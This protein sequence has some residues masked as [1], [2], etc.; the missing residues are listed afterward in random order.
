LG[1]TQD[2]KEFTGFVDEF[3]A[4]QI[5]FYTQSYQGKIAKYKER[6]LRQLD[7]DKPF[8]TYLAKI[9]WCKENQT[10][11]NKLVKK[12][13]HGDDLFTLA[14]VVVNE[15]GTSNNKAKEAI[16]YAYLNRTGGQVREPK[17][18]EISHYKILNARFAGIDTTGRYTFVPNFIK[19][20]EAANKRLSDPDK[21]DDPTKGATHW[22]S[23]SGL[24]KKRSDC[25]GDYYWRG[26]EYN[27]CFP[28]WARDKDDPEVQ[29][30]FKMGLHFNP[31]YK[32]LSVPHVDSD[33]FLFYIG[34]KY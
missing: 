2:V 15:A 13:E 1:K 25:F 3:F 16:A 21:K 32:E 19:S 33:D 14:N 30:Y 10:L 7:T 24:K 26:G 28:I 9:N 4:K 12:N 22:V 34:V 29:R 23:P 8:S 31:G 20:L 18:N 27:K 17:K 6:V 11:F 5:K